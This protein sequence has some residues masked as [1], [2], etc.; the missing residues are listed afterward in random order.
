MKK[1]VVAVL[2]SVLLVGSLFAGLVDDILVNEQDFTTRGF[3]TGKV[4]IFE[5]V[6][7][8]V[9]S[10]YLKYSLVN[11]LAKTDTEFK[12]NKWANEL[13]EFGCSVG[14][15]IGI[16]TTSFTAFGL[17]VEGTIVNALEGNNIILIYPFARLILADIVYFDIGFGLGLRNVGTEED[18][19]CNCTIPVTLGIN[20]VTFNNFEYFVE[21]NSCYVGD[22]VV[23]KISNS[24]NLEGEGLTDKQKKE[25][26]NKI[27]SG[28][29]SGRVAVSVGG[30]V[31]F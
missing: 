5:N 2:M 6:V 14:A 21:V 19:S 25:A 23:E 27:M 29:V 16:Q 1:F 11:S 31:N 26:Q 15:S 20:I 8:H 17:A 28:W 18:L 24:N 12:G 3:A 13:N 22:Y 9:S 10:N 7:S 30:K 4:T